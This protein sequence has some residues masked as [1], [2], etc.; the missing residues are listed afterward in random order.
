MGLNFKTGIDVFGLILI[1]I[2]FFRDKWKKLPRSK[3]I[4]NITAYV[5]MSLVAFV[6]L[7]PIITSLPHV[8]RFNFMPINLTPF[9]D[10]ILGY[11]NPEMEMLLNVLMLVPFGFLLPHF[12]KMNLI[13]IIMVT[14]VLSFG[15]E[16]VQPLLNDYRASD[17]TDVIT[18][19]TGGVLGYWIY[20][21]YKPFEA[22]WMS[23]L[24]RKEYK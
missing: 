15:I 20:C 19:T 17:I 9:N 18:N 14:F 10:Y 13:K 1:Y 12:K 5:Y 16:I 6:T 22:K 4:L 3:R 21:V 8:F 7:M 24:D 11:G 2:I 23:I